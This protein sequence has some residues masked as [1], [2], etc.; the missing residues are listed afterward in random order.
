VERALSDHV[1]RDEDHPLP[2]AADD[3]GVAGD[4]PDGEQLELVG[5]AAAVAAELPHTQRL[6]L[7]GVDGEAGLLGQLA[8][9]RVDEALAGLQVASGVAPSTGLVHRVGVTFLH[10]Q[11]PA[12]VDH[13]DGGEPVHPATLARP[14]IR[15]R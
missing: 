5:A 9:G 3:V 12:G 1:E 8:H 4:G 6:E 2:L 13:G 14:H 10:Q 7:T 15:T 11:A